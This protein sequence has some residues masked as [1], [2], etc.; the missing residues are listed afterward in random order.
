MRVP[1][2]QYQ[3]Y[4]NTKKLIEL[5]R[6]GEKRVFKIL[7]VGANEHQMLEKFLPNDDITY[8]DIE[9]PKNLLNNPKYVL[10][11]ATDMSFKDNEY[12]IV[13]AL[14][15]YEHIP[16]EKREKF[17]KELYRVS[18]I[19]FIVAAPFYSQEVEASEKRL[20]ELFKVI[21]NT[22]YRWLQEHIE[23]TL[24]ML[25]TTKKNLEAMKIPYYVYEHG[26]L[27]IWEKLTRIHFL[28]V[29]DNEL[30]NYR[31]Y[32]D[33]Y[34]NQY[35]EPY[36]YDYNSYRKFIIGYK[37]NINMNT[38]EFKH[39]KIPQENLEKLNELEDEFNI[40]FNNK[41]LKQDKNDI[42]T[43]LKN[44][45]NEK[46][47]VMFNKLEELSIKKEKD[48]VQIYIRDEDSYNEEKSII[49]Q[50]NENRNIFYK[51]LEIKKLNNLKGIR[52]DPSVNQCAIKIL[53]LQGILSNGEIIDF[54]K[55]VKTNGERILKDDIYIFKVSDPQILIENNENINNLSKILIKI[56]YI[57]KDINTIILLEE[58]FKENERL[59]N[60]SNKLEAENNIL[61]EDM[62]IFRDISE[63]KENIEKYLNTTL[64][65]I[66]KLEVVC[67]E[68]TL[69]GRI[70]KILKRIGIKKTSLVYW[71]FKNPKLIFKGL[72][73]LKKSGIQGVRA[74]IKGKKLS[75][76]GNSNYENKQNIQKEEISIEEINN[77]IEKFSYK[78]KFSIIM[79][80]YNVDIKWL[81]KAI[82]SVI[83]QTY[84]YWEICI[85]D[86]N[87]TKNETIE[88]I[89]NIKD[90][91]I[92][93]LIL[94][95]NKGI[96]YASNSAAKMAT[97][98]YLILMDNDDE[99]REEALYHIATA[100]N[101]KKPD[102][103]YSDEDKITLDG[104]RRFPFLKPDWSPDLLYSQMYICHLLI[105]K[106]EIF[107]KVDGFRSQFNGSQDYDLMLRMSEITQ[108]IYHIPKVLYS[109]RE[110]P[111][112]TAMNPN[113][114]PY[115]HIAGLKALDEHLK[116]KYGNDAYANETDHLFVYDARFGLKE[117]AVKVS[118][119]IPTKDKLELLKP[120]VESILSKTS[121]SNYE[122][123]ILNNNSSE[124]ETY[125]W[126]EYIQDKYSNVRVIDAFYEF[127]WSKLNNHGIKE[128]NGDVYVFL[129]NDT[130]IIS[131]D[132]L[133]RL[134]ENAMREDV[135]TVGA[136]LLYEDGTI[137]HAGVVLG[138]GG[139]ADHVFKGMEPVHFGSPY[140]SPMVNRNVLASTGA[141]LTIS[142]KVIEKIGG[143]DEKFI[144]CGSDVE[145]SLRARKYNLNNVYNSKVRLYHL[146]SKSRDSYIPPIDFE[147]SKIHYHEYLENGDPYYNSQLDLESTSPRIKG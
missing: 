130:I 33:E 111:S 125:E 27:R 107:D 61:I 9:L 30:G 89:K 93:K 42:V 71:I 68:L 114:K 10:G 69:K 38:T 124:D 32:I 25:E 28:S 26:D 84:P 123:I 109:W 66:S 3:R 92:K 118:I 94:E 112:S 122:I 72:S 110:I 29:I 121:Y 12:D 60:L 138:M 128:A 5:V 49:L 44:F 76:E 139:W 90:D 22:E 34:Y 143:F 59:Y 141:C 24:P 23:N 2:D 65:H 79:P 19:C 17:I 36:D 127:N 131:P 48:Y 37:Q 147:M 64:E 96:S 78:P 106:K 67:K 18:K 40:L 50:L 120:C 140:V 146:E 132:W 102:I 74:K 6:D 8:L 58:L 21:Y 14:D 75:L 116:K 115:A 100:I 135:G 117:E 142:K 31:M 47:T 137:Q 104:V 73:E 144:I 97:G 129:N 98:E 46:E 85:V 99:M 119:I 7:E 82:N 134:A 39:S 15:V 56:E 103:L 54:S 13:I 35:I 20:N 51:E 16:I 126:F 88:Y 113:S 136:L 55:N 57:T 63:E 70:K 81:D 52:I 41:L 145:I 86:D 80:V 1:F 105:I 83:N 101:E 133:R 45:I 43:I 77:R 87:S 53:L 108:N 11:D 95:E 62:K 91:K 4:N